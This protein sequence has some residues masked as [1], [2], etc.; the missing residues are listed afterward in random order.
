MTRLL[1]ALLLTASVAFGQAVRVSDR[2]T[3]LR[4]VTLTSPTNGQV[5]KYNS[6]TSKWEN[7][8]ASAGSVAVGDIT[9]L[10]TDVATFLATP[11]L[12]N[13]STAVSDADIART[14]STNT[15]LS[16]RAASG[17][18]TFR[19]LQST[20]ATRG[21]EL[22]YGADATCLLR[23]VGTIWQYLILGTS[24]G[25]TYIDGS[26]VF[27][28]GGGTTAVTISGANA[29]FAGSV[30]LNNATA[31]ATPTNAARF[32][33]ASGEMRVIDSS[34]NNT[35]ISPHPKDAP[36]DL[37][38]S[39]PGLDN[40]DRTANV[41]T[42]TVRWWNHTRRQR[43]D[44]LDMASRGLGVTGSEAE[45]TGAWNEVF[46]RRQEN[47]LRCLIVETFAQYETRTGTSLWPDP[48][49]ASLT[50]AQRWDSVQ[51]AEVARTTAL[52]D[53]W[54]T[55]RDAAPDPATFTEPE[56]PIYTAQ[57]A[58]DFE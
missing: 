42:G 26:S 19:V 23:A 24:T 11:T 13:L 48:S 10:G 47:R 17:T 50:P 58:P 22:V 51:A 53:A 31:P 38:E 28:R 14:D 40:I 57:P 36:A 27:L 25:Q 55:R 4:D 56:P 46:A 49:W 9:G 7:G 20:D 30:T 2:L 1:L 43:I 18:S 6:S 44:Q 39:G 15:S 12:A 45:S 35:I 34:G 54:V 8:T 32:Y 37:Y 52:H 21:V 5:L 16:V 33:A 41:F 3:L 29:T